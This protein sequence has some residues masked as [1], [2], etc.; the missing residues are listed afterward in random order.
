MW[1]HRCKPAICALPNIVRAGDMQIK[2][3]STPVLGGTVYDPAVMGVV[4][5]VED[6][7]GFAEMQVVSCT[8]TRPNFIPATSPPP[9]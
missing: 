4:P 2:I 8:E 3:E 5:T 6:A 9:L 7:F 1:W